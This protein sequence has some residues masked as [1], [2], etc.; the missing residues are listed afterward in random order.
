MQRVVEVVHIGL[1]TDYHAWGLGA[2]VGELQLCY[3]TA[4]L[5]AADG[6]LSRLLPDRV[7][8]VENTRTWLPALLASA[9]IGPAH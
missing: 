5:I 4:L 9:Y 3:Y 8:C 7:R 1:Q 2:Y 6:E